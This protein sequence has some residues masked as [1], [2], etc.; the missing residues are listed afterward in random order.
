MEEKE[1]KEMQ[2][3]VVIPVEEEKKGHKKR[4]ISCPNIYWFFNFNCFFNHLNTTV[5][6]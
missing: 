5:N 4:A 3:T 2:E 6:S 1:K